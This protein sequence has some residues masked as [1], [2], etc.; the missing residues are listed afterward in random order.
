MSLA[1]AIAKDSRARGGVAILVN[2][3]E[4]I[5]Q[6][7]KLRSWGEALNFMDIRESERRK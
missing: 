2:L 6:L 5:L 7:S 1:V 4:E 3:R